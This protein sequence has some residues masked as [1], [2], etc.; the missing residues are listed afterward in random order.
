MLLAYSAAVSELCFSPP[1]ADQFIHGK[2]CRNEKQDNQRQCISRQSLTQNT[3]P[4]T[5]H[6]CK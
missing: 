5:L 4:Y 1:N 3:N 2:I 6:G